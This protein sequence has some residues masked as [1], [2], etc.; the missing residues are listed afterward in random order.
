MSSQCKYWWINRGKREGGK[1]K[2]RGK[3]NERRRGKGGR[4]VGW[5][6]KMERKIKGKERGFSHCLFSLLIVSTALVGVCEFSVR[7]RRHIVG[8]LRPY[9]ICPNRFRIL[10]YNRFQ[11]GFSA[12]ALEFRICT[13]CKNIQYVV[14]K[15]ISNICCYFRN[16]Q[17]WTV[18]AIIYWYCFISLYFLKFPLYSW[19]AVT[20]LMSLT[21]H[22]AM[23]EVYLI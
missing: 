19:G 13:S 15:P 22:A 7:L 3:G 12:V 17:H 6:L 16:K 23:L 5:G 20:S 1:R 9:S 2:E 14:R 11:F 10:S 18:P 21:Q 4:G 8:T